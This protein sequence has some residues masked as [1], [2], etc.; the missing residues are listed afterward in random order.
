MLMVK[1]REVDYLEGKKAI[2]NRVLVLVPS[3]KVM[4]HLLIGNETTAE[5]PSNEPVRTQ[6]AYEYLGQDEPR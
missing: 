4:K 6:Q 1:K 3:V 5:L 2:E